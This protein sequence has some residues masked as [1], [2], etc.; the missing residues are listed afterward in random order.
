MPRRNF[1]SRRTG[2]P[3][4]R[5]PARRAYRKR[6]ARP[7]RR[8]VYRRR[9]TKKR[10]LNV[11]SRKKRDEMQPLSDINPTDRKSETFTNSGAEFTAGADRNPVQM[12]WLATG[13]SGE[14]APGVLGTILES[15]TRTAQTCFMRGLSE[16]IDVETNDGNAWLWRR[17]VFRM[18]G[19]RLFD[20]GQDNAPLRELYF[21]NGTDGYARLATDWFGTSA[22][23]TLNAIVFKGVEGDDWSFTRIEQ[24]QV[25][26]KRV[27]VMYDKVIKIA[28]GN[29]A[30]VTR[31]YKMWHPMNKNLVYNDD[32]TG[33]SEVTSHFSTEGKPGMGDV[34][35][36]DIIRP[37]GFA[38]TTAQIR[39]TPQAALYWHEK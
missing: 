5:Y 19:L 35:V 24:A 25:D 30:G 38:D 7:M 28:S 8:T 37:N 21:R 32:E 3:R 23:S 2:A 17:I 39:W 33:A 9:Y 26:T 18:K 11:T 12:L 14:T 10:M 31:Q 6:L 15:A 16:R 20:V 34:Y 22:A 4:R 29:E 1:R 13:R 36:M 27:S